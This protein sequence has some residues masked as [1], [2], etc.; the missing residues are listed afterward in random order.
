[1]ESFGLGY[2]SLEKVRPDL[3]MTS[4]TP[5]G[6]TGPYKDYQVT[7]LTIFAMSGAMH[8]EGLPER[9][10]LRYGGEIAQYF[11]RHRGRGGDY[12]GLP[13]DIADRTGEWIDISIHESMV[14]HPHQIGRRAP[15]AYAG[16]LDTRGRIRSQARSGLESYATGTFHCSDGYISLLPLGSRMWPN[17]AR[18]IEM[19]GLLDDPRFATSDDR[20]EHQGE[21]AAMFQGWLDSHTRDEVF[22]AAHENGLPC[23]PVLEVDQVMADRH[24]QDRDYF[25]DIRHEEAGTLAY[26]GAPFRLSDTAVDDA[27]PARDW[28]STTKRYSAI[29]PDWR[30]RDERPE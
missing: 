26:P 17:I 19:P 11:G 6:Q 5:F 13:G 1:M 28:A 15:F 7:E 10:P 24:L 2:G 30:G 3:V 21:L 9:Q 16:E 12:G 25:V 29:S 14:G 18:M 4:V 27:R 22:T 20:I 23:A 8:R